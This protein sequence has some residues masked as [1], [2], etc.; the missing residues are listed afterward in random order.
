MNDDVYLSIP[1]R[2]DSQSGKQHGNVNDLIKTKM[3]ASTI[4]T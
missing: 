4:A 2:R 1:V 3:F